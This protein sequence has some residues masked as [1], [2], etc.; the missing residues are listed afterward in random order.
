VVTLFELGGTWYVGNPNGDA[1]WA[2]NLAA[3]S[4]AVVVRGPERTGVVATLLPAGPER[5]RV[6]RNTSHQPPPASLIYRLGRRHV[7]AVGAY[8][9]LEPV[10]TAKEEVQ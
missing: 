8:F 5:D 6:V 3:S 1:Q 2:R 9:R 4:T 10:K 7:S